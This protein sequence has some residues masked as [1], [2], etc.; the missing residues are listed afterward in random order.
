MIKFN[1]KE[2]F[3]KENVRFI[4]FMP[5][6]MDYKETNKVAKTI[7]KRIKKVDYIVMPESRG[8]LLGTIVAHKLKTNMIPIRKHGKLPNE[9]IGAT[10]EYKTEY[11]TTKIDIPKIDIKNKTCYFID[12]VYATGGTYKACKKLIKKMGGIM[13]GGICLYDVGISKNKEIYSLLTKEDIKE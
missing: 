10:E 9:F 2:N 7:A 3:P 5:F 4:D 13:K 6:F 1:V 12:D 11:S 8:Y